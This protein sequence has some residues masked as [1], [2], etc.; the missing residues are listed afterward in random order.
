LSERREV[1]LLNRTQDRAIVDAQTHSGFVEVR[2]RRGKLVCRLD[3]VRM[4]L[5]WQDR[6]EIELIDLTPYLR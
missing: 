4:L 2:T 6:Q 5:E 3:P 1:Y